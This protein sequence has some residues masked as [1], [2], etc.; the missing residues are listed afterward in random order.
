VLPKCEQHQILGVIRAT[1][2]SRRNVMTLRITA[3]TL[4]LTGPQHEGIVPAMVFAMPYP[5]DE[6]FGGQAYLN[7]VALRPDQ[8]GVLDTASY[9]QR[10]FALGCKQI[11]TTSIYDLAQ[12][13]QNLR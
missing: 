12:T 9:R 2:R 1:K 8:S 11:T 5:R 13:E 3:K 7:G 10:R 4:A 6:C